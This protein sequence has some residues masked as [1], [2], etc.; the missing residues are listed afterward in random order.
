MK[1]RTQ[2][3]CSLTFSSTLCPPSIILALKGM[4]RGA[5]LLREK[6]NGALQVDWVPGGTWEA[7]FW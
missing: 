1:N 3:C 4:R 6:Q 7:M 5:F 2:A